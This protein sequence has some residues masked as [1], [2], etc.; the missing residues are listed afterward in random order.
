MT[1]GP[2]EQNIIEQCVRSGRPLPAKIK[3]APTLH[4]GLE[5]FYKA[6]LDLTSCRSIGEAYGQ[7]PWTATRDWCNEHDITG[8]QREDLYYLVRALDMEYLDI[9]R[10]KQK[11]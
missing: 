2:F 10:K 11:G 1:Q 9:V 3:N 5:L 7:I 4:G 8:E 6:F